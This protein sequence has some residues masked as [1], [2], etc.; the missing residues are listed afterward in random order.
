MPSYQA[1]FFDFDGVLADTEPLHH[2]CW[3]ETLLP[4]GIDLRWDWYRDNCIGVA[5]R[6]MI[7]AICRH[8]AVPV[9]PDLVW[10]S[11]SAKQKLYG[12]RVAETPP[13]PKEVLD[14][15]HSLDG[16][17]L[18]VV[19]SSGR[20]EVEPLLMRAGIRERFSVVVCGEDVQRHKP[21]PDPYVLAARTLRVT[22]ALV[23]ED[24]EAGL[25][26]GRAAG[27]DVLRIP[28]P[29]HLPRLLL[30]RLAS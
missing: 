12:R 2:S 9:D 22:E 23:V 5:D 29:S 4:F 3:R 14:L 10:P 20:A 28:H 7:E 6:A 15:I 16:C 8:A 25:A 18:G 27:F 19:S 11:Y 30:E 1:I 26:S 17:P 21:A 13:F 24:S